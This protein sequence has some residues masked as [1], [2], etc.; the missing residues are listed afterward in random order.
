MN[1]SVIAPKIENHIISKPQVIAVRTRLYQNVLITEEDEKD[2]LKLDFH[3]YGLDDQLLMAEKVIS[4][5]SGFHIDPL[6][7]NH[8][9]WGIAQ[10]TPATWKDFGHGDIMNPLIQ[11]DVMSHMWSKGL[12][13]RWDC[14]RMLK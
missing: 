7:H 13:N 2:Y 12:Q 4:C 5:E 14:Y 6:P 10:F 3:K 11:I 9:S 8:I 1:E